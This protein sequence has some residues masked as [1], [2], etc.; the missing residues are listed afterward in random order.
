MPSKSDFNGILE[1]KNAKRH[2]LLRNVTCHLPPFTYQNT[3]SVLSPS[4]LRNIFRE[5]SYFKNGS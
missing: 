5:N 3:I 2:L 1:R 4:I